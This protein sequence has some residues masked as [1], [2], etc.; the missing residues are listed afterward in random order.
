MVNLSSR[1]N[2]FDPDSGAP[3]KLSRSKLENFLRCPRC[4]YL[5]RRMGI[6]QPSGP[7]FSLNAAVDHLLKKEFDRYRRLQKP[8]PLMTEFKIDAVPFSHPSLDEWRNNFTGISFFHQPTNFVVSGAVDDL[9]VN[10]AG[11]IFVVDYKATSKDSEVDLNS[12]WQKSYKNQMEIYQWLFKQNGFPVSNTGYFVYLN[13]R[14]DREALEGRLEFVAKIIPY[15][16][17]FDW[18]EKALFEARKCL[19][20][21]QLPPLNPGCEYCRYRQSARAVE[22]V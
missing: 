12:E 21:E 14:R 18:V 13:G 8:H 7:P 5:D 1:R 22:A 17:N 19:E 16:G 2:I 4:F 6:A 11:D 10:A 3:F 9:W 20:S 15:Q